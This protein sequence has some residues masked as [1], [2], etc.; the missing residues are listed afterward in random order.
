M[1]SPAR[2]DP[3]RMHSDGH[4][5]SAQ[6][7]DPGAPRFRLIVGALDAPEVRKFRDVLAS[8]AARA[9]IWVTVDLAGLDDGH[10]LTAVALLSTA[11]GKLQDR[12]SALTACNPPRGLARVLEAVPVPVT[13]ERLDASGAAGIQVIQVGA[14]AAQPP[15]AARRG[16]MP[17]GPEARRA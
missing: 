11:A 1:S 12:G 9:R 16:H 6:D 13:Y 2:P 14:L 17:A 15:P 5:L 8:L 3:A 4:A 7:S 10:H